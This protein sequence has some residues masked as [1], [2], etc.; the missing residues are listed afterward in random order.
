[1]RATAAQILDPDVPKYYADV[2][3]NPYRYRF[4]PAEGDRAGSFELWSVGPD[5]VDDS[6]GGGNDD[7]HAR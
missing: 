7:I 4:L 1:M 2:W 5:G 6:V 3:G